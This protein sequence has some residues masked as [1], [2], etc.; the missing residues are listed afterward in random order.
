MR[1]F[2]KVTT[3]VFE[4]GQVQEECLYTKKLIGGLL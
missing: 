4:L 1:L 2:N 3:D